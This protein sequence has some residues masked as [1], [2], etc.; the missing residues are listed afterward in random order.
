ME[1]EKIFSPRPPPKYTE[2]LSLPTHIPI[3]VYTH[4]APPVYLPP[5]SPI[6]ISKEEDDDDCCYLCCI[7]NRL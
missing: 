4:L 5:R 3:R 2:N 1:K 6:D 7:R